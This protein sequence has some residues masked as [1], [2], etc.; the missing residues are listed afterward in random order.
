MGEYP[1]VDYSQSNP[2]YPITDSNQIETIL[3]I[4]N[5]KRYTDSET[6]TTIIVPYVGCNEMF[7]SKSDDEEELLPW[8]IN[9]ES[10]IRTKS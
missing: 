9:Y 2:I 5:L 6:G 7:A 3:D 8:E 10:S 1:N 4:F